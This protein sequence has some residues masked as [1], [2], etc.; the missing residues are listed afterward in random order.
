MVA[1]AQFST[2]LHEVHSGLQ[3]IFGNELEQL[4]L[5]GSYARGEQDSESD[6]DLLALVN[7]P[8][9]QL[10]GYRRAVNHLSSEIDLRHN[11]FLSIMLQ[12][13]ETFARYSGILP[14]FQNVAREGI[15]IG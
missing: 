5:Y 13:T 1:T 7:M 6:I 11:V 14:F 2:V 10:A 3:S 15:P 9:E 8:Q 12:D 4:L